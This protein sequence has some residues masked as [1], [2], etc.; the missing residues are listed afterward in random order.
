MSREINFITFH[1]LS[2]EAHILWA[3]PTVYDA[4]GYEP[5]EL[6][7]RCGYDIVYPDDFEMGKKF[8]KE[9]FINDMIA[10][11]VFVRYKTK[12]GHPIP[13]LGVA[14]LCY[15]FAINS[16]TV[17]D[18]GVKSYQQRQV[19]STL[20]TRSAV[21]KK[22]EFERMKRHHQAFAANTWDHQMMELEVRVCLILNRF[23]RNLIV[24]YASSACEKVFHVGPDDII[25]K[26]I[27]LY[28][29]ADDLAPFVEQVDIIKAST[30][31][32]QIR[33]WFQ[34]PNQPQEIPCEA[35][36]FGAADGIV[37]VVRRCKPFVRKHLIGNR[38]QYDNQSRGSSLSSRSSRSLRWNPYSSSQGSEFSDSSFS[39]TYNGYGFNPPQN[40]PRAT[41]DRIKILELDEKRA[42]PIPSLLDDPFLM[43]ERA[44]APV[45][46]AFK[47]VIVQHYSED[48][49]DD[50]VD[51]DTVVRGVAISRLDDSDVDL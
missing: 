6:V 11:Q 5:E 48:D 2:P 8:H 46:P 12:D 19:H 30:S 33:F 16:V 47:E 35:I 13:C 34:S 39:S 1:D 27:L 20:M 22:E 28:I 29:R 37:A 45:A 9:S 40:V 10:G 21:S 25:G 3:S 4:L 51:V 36:I 42:R 38:E 31:I 23:T 26:P 7:G 32:S 44:T 50:G 49:G 15:D 14:C 17:L 41:L 18:P 43:H 24:M